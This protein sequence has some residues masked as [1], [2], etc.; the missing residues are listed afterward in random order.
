MWLT[1]GWKVRCRFP[2]YYFGP[3]WAKCRFE[4]LKATSTTEFISLDETSSSSKGPSLPFSVFGHTMIKVNEST[5]Y[6][7]GGVQSGSVSRKTWIINP[8]KN[9]QIKKGPSLKMARCFHSS[10]M[11]KLNGK[12]YIIVAGG[13]NFK[14]RDVYKKITYHLNSV[15]LLDTS[16]YFENWKIGMISY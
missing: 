5:I 3:R 13:C 14:R 6:L 2:M 9:F 11:M 10:A 7:I 8:T 12:D 15:E 1:G 4:D 16:T